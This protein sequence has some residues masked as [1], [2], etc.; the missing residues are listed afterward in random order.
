MNNRTKVNLVDM[1]FVNNVANMMGGAL[2][3]LG[4]MMMMM[5]MMNMKKMFVHHLDRTSFVYS[6]ENRI[7]LTDIYVSLLGDDSVVTIRNCTF[8]GN[9]AKK[10]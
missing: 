9:S 2:A 7:G 3:L 1:I 4:K 10:V 5:M 8:S 6:Q